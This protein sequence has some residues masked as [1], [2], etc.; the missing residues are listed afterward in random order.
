[1]ISPSNSD[2]VSI[3]AAS[4]LVLEDGV[5]AAQHASTQRA[6]VGEDL[7]MILTRTEDCGDRAVQHVAKLLSRAAAEPDGVSEE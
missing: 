2:T 7:R 5:H 3:D 6:D 4:F 1:M